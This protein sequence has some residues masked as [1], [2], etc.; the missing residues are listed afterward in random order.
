MI[1][2][3]KQTNMDATWKENVRMS[4]FL[5]IEEDVNIGVIIYQTVDT[6]AY[7]IEDTLWIPPTPKNVSMLTN[8]YNHT[9]IIVHKF[10][11]TS[12]AHMRAHVAMVS[13]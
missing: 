7:V 10:V 4:M 8:A 6:F 13:I 5:E 1:V 12:M 2:G 11:Q 3:I 9:K